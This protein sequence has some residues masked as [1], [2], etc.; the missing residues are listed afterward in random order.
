MSATIPQSS[1]WVVGIDVGVKSPHK[2]AIFDRRTGQRIRRTFSVPR[3]W[4]G[5]QRFQEILAQ[6]DRVQIALDPADSAW[7]PLAGGLL[8]LGF[9]VYLIDPK[10]SSRFRKA[11]SA[12]VKS[13][14]V[15]AQALARLLMTVPD[16]LDPLRLPPTSVARLRDLV[17][18]R[19]RLAEEIG[20]RKRRIQSLVGQIQP[21]LMEA[22]GQDKFLPAYRAFLRK[23]VDPRSVVRLGKKR[24]H[25]F[26]NRRYRAHHFDPSR[27]EA[28]LEAAHSGARLLELQQQ[29]DGLFFE[30]EQIQLEVSMELDLF[31]AEEAQIKRLE[32]Q[33]FVVYRTLDPDRVLQTLPGFGPIISA[34][35]LGETGAVQRFPNVGKYRGFVSLI[36]RHKATGQSHNERQKLRKAGPRLLKKY[37]YLAAETARKCDLEMAAFYDRCRRKGHVHDQAV[38]AVANKLAGRAY[39]V[40]KRMD[41]NDLPPYVFRDLEGHPIPKTEA[42]RRAQKEFPGPVAQRRQEALDAEQS[43]AQKEENAPKRTRRPHPAYTRPPKRDASS[44][45]RGT[46]R[47]VSEV[48]AEIGIDTLVRTSASDPSHKPPP[49]S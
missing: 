32:Q 23:Y 39:A 45:G 14:K 3:T 17:R 35:V 28:I 49:D 15:D 1:H 40:M 27:T 10:T 4:D 7:R 42:K 43:S 16:K 29:G 30:P 41:Q 12:H 31:E 9:E 47:H 37:L 48:L 5:I 20:N 44:L 19:D 33:I 22:L 6:A 38:C 26:L 13:D 24:L 18:H 34:G 8:A 11:L 2:V 36:P 46:P 25:D 21:T